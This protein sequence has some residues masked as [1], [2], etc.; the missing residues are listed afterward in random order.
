MALPGSFLLLAGS[1]AD[2]GGVGNF[3][4]LCSHQ[5]CSQLLLTVYAAN[6]K[7]P[8]GFSKKGSFPSLNLED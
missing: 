6:M 8:V 4:R 5:P 7:P 2:L 1:G 3:G